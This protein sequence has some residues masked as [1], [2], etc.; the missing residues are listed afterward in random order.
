MYV[1]LN[2]NVENLWRVVRLS[3]TVAGQ[4]P[5]KSEAVQNYVKECDYRHKIRINS[6]TKAKS[7]IET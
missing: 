2:I 3:L 7:L 4:G 5:M 6:E 1:Q